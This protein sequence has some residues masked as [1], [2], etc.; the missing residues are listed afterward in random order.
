MNSRRGRDMGGARPYR[1]AT[2][3]RAAV[4]PPGNRP[5][6]RRRRRADSGAAAC[7]AGDARKRPPPK[8]TA[9]MTYTPARPDALLPPVRVNLYSDTQTRPTPE[10][11]A[12]MVAAELGDEQHGDD[13]TVHALCDRMAALL[14]KP[15]AMF[16]PSG[17]MCNQISILTHC[18]PG[19]EI[20]A[21]Q[22][23]HIVTSEG[24]G[25]GA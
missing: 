6:N 14:G 20:I 1:V 12:A 25:P 16:L 11:K 8:G 15:A 19:D 9:T 13:P 22:R 2:A 18:R 4:A 3:G 5:S 17:T 7:F 21:H 24:G 10:M 23:A